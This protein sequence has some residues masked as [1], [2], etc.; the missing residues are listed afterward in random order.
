MARCGISTPRLAR[1]L[2]VGGGSLRPWPW[3]A[4]GL[5]AAALAACGGGGSSPVVN[6]GS[7]TAPAATSTTS[8][9]TTSTTAAPAGN[10]QVTITPNS[11]LKSPQ[12]V[13]VA[14]SGFSPGESLVITECAAEGASTGAGDC[15]LGGLQS[16]T[17]DGSGKVTAQFRVVKGPFGAN[18]IVCSTTQACLVSVTQATLSPTQEADAPISFG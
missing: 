17:A 16:V 6:S 1:P 18:K 4:A 10:Q 8:A 5:L 15:N 11:G 13:T 9:P 12:T 2:V 14:A 7:T 3:V